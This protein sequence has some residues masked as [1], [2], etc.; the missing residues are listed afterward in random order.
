MAYTRKQTTKGGAAYYEI[1]CQISRDAPEY[2][3]RWYVP[4]G[5]SEK[6]IQRELAKQA[7]EFERRCHAGEVKTKKQQKAERE[8][9]KRRAD[10]IQTVRQYGERVFMPAKAV[11]ISEN[12]RAGFQSVLD[13]HVY[14]VIGDVKLPDV[15]SAMLS[16]LLLD[17]QAT[18]KAHGTV[19][20][21]YTILSLLF[22]MAYLNDVI[23]R[24]PMDK[25]SRPKPRKDEEKQTDV[26]AFS[27]EEMRYIFKC[28]DAEPLKWQCFVR[29]LA[30]TGIRRGEACGLEWRS[31]DFAA[32]TI[33]IRQTLNYTKAK[34]VY[35]DTTKNKK[36]RVIDVDPAVTALLKRL[37][38]EQSE[39][40]ISKYVFTQDDSSEPMFP[41]SPTR[42]FT[43]FGRRYGVQ[44]FHPHKLR[45]SFASIAITSG[46]DVAS[47]SEILGH[48]DKAVTLRVYAHSDAEARKK[49]SGIFID[50][51]KEEKRA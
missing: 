13:L 50:A 20:R 6:A 42:Y 24:N 44:H 8:E 19:I 4:D 3:T 35:I 48:S 1:R 37:R 49:A 23:Q 27:A 46:A 18:G 14:P 45:H 47:V 26:E 29:L 17:F 28:L 7:A 21:V 32:N 40:C 51:L 25:V 22:K 15:T 16:A 39:K 9:A 2:S 11:T 10:A 34:G 30:V 5:W 36:E 33:T 41:Q 31:V 43:T 38:L 12:T